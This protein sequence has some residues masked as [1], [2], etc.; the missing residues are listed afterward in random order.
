MASGLYE[1]GKGEFLVGTIDLSSDTIKAALIDLNDVAGVITGAT[2]ATPI[3]R[4][5]VV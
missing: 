4:K 1:Q 3:D 5:S 2:N